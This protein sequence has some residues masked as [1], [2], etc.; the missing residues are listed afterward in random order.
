M[1]VALR[2]ADYRWVGAAVV[3]YFLVEFAAGVRWQI[4][5]KVQEDSP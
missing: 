4:L 2:T 3:A 1:G 5:L